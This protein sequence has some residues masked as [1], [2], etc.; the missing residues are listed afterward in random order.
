MGLLSQ[1]RPLNWDE[2]KKYAKFVQERGIAQFIN[3]YHRS[4]DRAD[5]PFKWGDEVGSFSM[6]NGVTH[7][8][9]FVPSPRH[10]Q[11]SNELRTTLLIAPGGIHLSE[12]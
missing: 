3:I 10:V 1:G 2:T 4:K 5:A 7:K 11:D 9:S 8:I 12:I 6:L